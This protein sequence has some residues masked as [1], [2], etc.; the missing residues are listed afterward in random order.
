MLGNILSTVIRVA[1]LPIDA[2]SATLDV[3][4]GGDGSKTSRTD[5]GNPFGLLEEIRDA[6]ADTTKE[7]DQ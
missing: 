6:V 1:T 2:A 5:S 3:L 7:I 4:S